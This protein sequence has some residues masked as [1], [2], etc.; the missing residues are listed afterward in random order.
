MP[1]PSGK[2]LP[3]KITGYIISLLLFYFILPIYLLKF[4]ATPRFVSLGLFYLSNLIIIYCLYR[5]NSARNYSF[6]SLI[7]DVQERFNLLRVEYAKERQNNA[8]LKE[9]NRRYQSLK[10]VLEKINQDLDLDNVA[11]TLAAEVFSLIGDNKGLCLL[12][13]VDNQTQKLNL[14]K[15][16]KDDPTLVVKSKEGDIFDHWVLRHAGPL[17]IED[18]KNDFRFDLEKLKTQDSR[19]I[20][21]LISAPFISENKF[22]GLIR[23]DNKSTHSYSQDDLRFLASISDLGAL[24]LENSELYQK[25]QDLAIHDALTSLYTKGYFAQR[26]REEFKRCTRQVMPLSML[27][28]DIDLF[29][30]YN[31]QFGHTAGDIVLKEIS[32]IIR[33]SLSNFNAMISRFGGEEFCAVITGMDKNSA[34]SFADSLR[35]DIEKEKIILRRVESHVTVSIGVASFPVDATDE[36]ELI[37]R[38]DKALYKAK[39]KGRNR[40][41]CI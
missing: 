39:Q 2:V 30:N 34:C 24:A 12:Y 23:L 16:K 9:K 37:Q 40:V 10:S 38:T 8:A 20:S 5:K 27:M 21:S 31:D 41:C 32:R 13:L 25:T 28:L 3:L 1:N 7:Q 17:L 22:L 11:D 36:D 26:L 14:F 4:C 19:P 35:A 18:I 33:E 15:A 29:K 6:D